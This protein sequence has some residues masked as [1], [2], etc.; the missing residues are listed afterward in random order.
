MSVATRHIPTPA[1]FGLR[2]Q[3]SA[4][5][6]PEARR[7]VIQAVR[8]WELPLT[9]EALR[10]VELLASEVITNAVVHTAQT[11]QVSVRWTG[12]RLRVEVADTSAEL[13]EAVGSEA[14]ATSGRG[15]FLVDALA[16][17]WGM[18]SLETGGK[19]T[20]FEVSSSAVASDSRPAALARAA[21]P[22]EPG[23]PLPSLTTA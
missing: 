15:L 22:P 11:C 17:A 14:E 12:M 4:E 13:P 9:E 10:D 7:L 23:E 1:P 20:W 8:R 16:T 2:V 19:R 21:Q 6:V 5:A 18:E 3:P